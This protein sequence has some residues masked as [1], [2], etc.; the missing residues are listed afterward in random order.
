MRQIGAGTPMIFIIESAKWVFDRFSSK[1]EGR[2][3]GGGGRRRR[4][5]RREGDYLMLS[6]WLFVIPP[7]KLVVGRLEWEDKDKKERNFFVDGIKITFC[8]SSISLKP[9]KL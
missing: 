1:R 8:V 3:E 5:R 2:G 4:R 9:M 6:N 7:A